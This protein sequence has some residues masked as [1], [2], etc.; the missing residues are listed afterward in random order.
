MPLEHINSPFCNFTFIGVSILVI[1]EMPLEHQISD[2]SPLKGLCFNPC[3]N[4]N[5]SRTFIPLS[6]GLN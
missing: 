3:D 6:Q 2:I 4:G 1:M 5:A